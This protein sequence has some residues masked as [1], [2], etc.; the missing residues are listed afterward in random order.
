M[1][2]FFIATTTL[3]VFSRL[4]YQRPWLPASAVNDL[5]LSLDCGST[6]GEAIANGCSLDLTADAWLPQACYYDAEAAAEELS[7]LHTLEIAG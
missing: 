4:L 1:L 3:V 5:S 7:S 2:I 6:R